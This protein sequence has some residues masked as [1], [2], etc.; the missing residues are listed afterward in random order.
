MRAVQVTQT[1][2]P[3][4]LEIADVP[5]PAG[6]GA[7]LIDV[8]AAGISFPDLLLSRGQYQLKPDPPF[9]LGTEAAGVV[10]TAPEGSGFEPGDRVAA[11]VFGAFADVCTGMPQMTFKLPEELSFEQ[12]AGL[13]MNYHTAHFA[14]SRRAGL[15]E[16]ETLLVHGAAGGVGTAAIQV[17]RA[18][19]ARVVGVVS[20]EEKEMVARDAGAHEVVR[21]DAEW[22]EAD[23]VFDPVGGERLGQS[24][25]RL[26]AEGRLVVIGFTEGQIPS[27]KVNRLLFRNVSLIGAAWGH[28]ALERP[29]YVQEVAT[30]LERMAADG[31]V[32]PV[33]GRTYAFDQVPQALHDLDER[34]AIGKLILEVDKE[35]SA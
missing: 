29:D 23:V 33:V 1:T 3:D 24:L 28:F 25:K 31:H 8:R 18:L 6:D 11:F 20:T 4:G 2:G 12:G 13:V 22:P 32:A 26:K 14:L 19:G 10:R 5:E 27:V 7:V 35:P 30:D 15:R 17:G 21:A 9:T 34:R 16:G